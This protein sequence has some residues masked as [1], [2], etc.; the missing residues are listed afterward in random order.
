MPQ[1]TAICISVVQLLP[2]LYR[3]VPTIDDFKKDPMV[4]T[5]AIP[6]AGLQNITVDHLRVNRSKKRFLNL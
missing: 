4:V 3:E 2:Q 6:T 1:N 5:L